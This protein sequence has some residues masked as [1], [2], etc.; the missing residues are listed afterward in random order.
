MDIRSI[1]NIVPPARALG[2][3]DVQPAAVKHVATPADIP[4]P[5]RQP[6]TVPNMEQVAQ[7]VKNINKSMQ[8]LSQ[9]VE[10]TIDED[11]QRTI[12]KV[13]DQ[14]TKEVLRQMPTEEALEIAKA[15]D[16]AQG[17]LIKQQA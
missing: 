11:S 16:R 17:L 6:G 3:A 7:A 4:D 12:I 15:L 13:V 8:A 10:F 1:G 5:V 9:G 2:D 14:Q